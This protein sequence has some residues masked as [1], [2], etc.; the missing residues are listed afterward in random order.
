MKRTVRLISFVVPYKALKVPQCGTLVNRLRQ[1]NRVKV[2]R[3]AV[4]ARIKALGEKL[5]REVE[6]TQWHGGLQAHSGRP[7]NALRQQN[8]SL[9]PLFALL[10]QDV[11]VFGILK[12]TGA[13]GIYAKLELRIGV[14]K[15]DSEVISIADL[16]NILDA[17]RG[18][19]VSVRGVWVNQFE[20]GQEFVNLVVSTI[21]VT[22]PVSEEI[23]LT[24][25]NFDLVIQ[26]RRKPSHVN[27]RP[28]QAGA[29]A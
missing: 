18:W 20:N 14:P 10:E 2:D 4:N 27:P 7:F 8:L 28:K 16:E 24:V 17:M 19:N 5:G 21:P 6:W 3:D 15:E 25:E 26:T 13:E 9:D 12:D 11:P 29:T 23:E 22:E 1:V